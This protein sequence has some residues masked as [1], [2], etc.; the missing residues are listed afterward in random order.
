[1]NWMFVDDMVYVVPENRVHVQINSPEKRPQGVNGYTLHTQGIRV[2]A[3]LI[4]QQPFE[5]KA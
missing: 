4:A 2:P 3:L 1:M 5:R